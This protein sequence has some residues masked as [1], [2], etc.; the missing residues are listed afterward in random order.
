MVLLPSHLWSS[1][2]KVSILISVGVGIDR[3]EQGQGSRELG[4]GGPAGSQ[5]E[6]V[7]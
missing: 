2:V 3:R 5:T 4:S 6:L 7:V 1:T